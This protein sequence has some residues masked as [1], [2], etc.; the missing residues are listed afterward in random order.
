MLVIEPI[1]P[2]INREDRKMPVVM[3]VSAFQYSTLNRN[4]TIAPVKPP[5]PGSGI[6]TSM[7]R[8][9]AP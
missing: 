8:K 1:P 7:I 6:A 2:T 9:R 5:L 4:A 3:R